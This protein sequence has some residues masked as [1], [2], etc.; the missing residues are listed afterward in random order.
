MTISGIGGVVPPAVQGVDGS[1]PGER[2]RS[3]FDAV[4]QKLGMSTDDLRT[5]MSSGES[6][7]DVAQSKGVSAD[8]LE[9]TIKSALQSSGAPGSD[10]QL[11]DIASRIANRKGGHHHHHH[12]DAA[13][14][15]A[16]TAPTVA[17]PT[18]ATSTSQL[19]A[20]A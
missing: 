17:P 8:D 9:A 2:M 1:S 11:T 13:S 14:A 10:S 12:I 15:S 19:D 6:L 16:T 20:L 4:A 5:A 7:A 3:V 18:T